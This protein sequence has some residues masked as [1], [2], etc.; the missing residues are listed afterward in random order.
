MKLR[1]QV[2]LLASVI[3]SLLALADIKVD[4]LGALTAVGLALV[5]MGHMQ[6][7]HDQAV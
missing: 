5:L 3:G 1:G 7:E 4:P 6:A 2:A